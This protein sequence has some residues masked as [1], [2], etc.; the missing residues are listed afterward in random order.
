[1]I[2]LIYL[3]SIWKKRYTN[4][5]HNGGEIWEI[6]EIGID[7]YILDQEEKIKLFWKMSVRPS[8]CP[9]N[10]CAQKLKNG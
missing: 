4:F 1:M 3:F 7:I 10:L 9:R 8:F 2:W 6:V 5:G